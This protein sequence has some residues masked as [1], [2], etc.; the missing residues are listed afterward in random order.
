MSCGEIGENNVYAEW[1]R[2][3][4]Q[5]Y[6]T[7][8]IKRLSEGLQPD[9]FITSSQDKLNLKTVS[10][11]LAAG[12]MAS[13]KELKSCI[14]AV[15][16]VPSVGRG[17]S[18]QFIP[19]RFISG[20]KLTKIDKLL[21]AFDAHIFTETFKCNVAYSK[22][23]HGDGFSALKVKTS[24]LVGEVRKIVGKINSLLSGD[25]PPDLILNRHCPIDFRSGKS[26]LL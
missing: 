1:M 8:G 26:I 22:I 7:N 14:H 2:E 10:W 15:E 9:K 21:G 13:S 11:N 20:N 3:K 18:V 23:I 25:A 24:V 6:L 17:T 16:R 5:S 19:I 4:N 12:V